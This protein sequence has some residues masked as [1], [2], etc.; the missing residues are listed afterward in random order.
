MA[1]KS[2]F[3]ADLGHE[4]H[5]MLQRAATR[6]RSTQAITLSNRLHPVPGV[7]H[8]KASIYHGY[9]TG[10]EESLRQPPIRRNT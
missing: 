10:F 5:E 3:R 2:L 7:A 9:L 6:G 1:N 4:V 8:P